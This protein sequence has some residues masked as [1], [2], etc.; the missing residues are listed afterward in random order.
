VI[1]LL[2]VVLAALAL[3]S[4]ASAREEA[5]TRPYLGVYGGSTA[6]FP[7]SSHPVRHVIAAWSQGPVARILGS[8]GRIPMLGLGNGLTPAAIASGAGDAWLA[9]INR[10]VRERGSLVYVRPMGEMN[11]AWNGYCA[12]NENGSSRGAAYSTRNFRRAFA[13]I[14][15]LLHGGSRA[16]VSRKLRQ[17]GLRGVTEDFAWNPKSRLRVIWNPHGY[18]TPDRPGNQPSDYFPGNAYVDLVGADVYKTPSNVGHLTGMESIYDAH[19]GKPFAIPEWG[20][21]SVDDPD[22]VRQVAEFV[23]THRRTE[24][25]VL[26]NGRG[27]GVYDLARKPRSLAAYRSL[28]VPMGRRS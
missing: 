2:C 14:Y 10:A 3:G 17:A 15:I 8:L 26:Y 6:V 5:A 28:L 24:V 19:P 20:L 7:S 12:F 22:F 21:E 27:G 1:R 18:S 23:R 11:G 25:V 16:S 4:T 13:R 9:E